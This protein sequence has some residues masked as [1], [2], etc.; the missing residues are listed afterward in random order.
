MSEDD[1]LIHA[2]DRVFGRRNFD[3]TMISYAAPERPELLDALAFL[4]ARIVKRATS[5]RLRESSRAAADRWLRRHANT[6]IAGLRLERDAIGWCRTAR[7]GGAEIIPFPIERRLAA[8]GDA[9]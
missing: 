1:N 4:G 3:A 2:L 5:P 8:G 7:P 6:E 9:Q